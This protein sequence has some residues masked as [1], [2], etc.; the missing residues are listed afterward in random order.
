MIKEEV[1][2]LKTKKGYFFE[3][4]LAEVMVYILEME[5]YKKQNKHDDNYVAMLLNISIDD[6]QKYLKQLLNIGMIRKQKNKYIPIYMDEFNTSFYS[7]TYDLK[8]NNLL[9]EFWLKRALEILGNLQNDAVKN[10][11]M[12]QTQ[13]ISIEA[14]RQIKKELND[15]FHKIALICKEDR[16]NKE[17]IRAV[18][19]QYITCIK[20]SLGF[21]ISS[22]L[23]DGPYREH[24]NRSDNNL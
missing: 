13:L 2:R 19:F 17:L 8:F 1:E 15:C 4:P 12:N 7:D 5:E 14:D 20:S 22:F 23:S 16:G 21:G 18:N 6:E 3:N 10:I 11:F 24:E 9:K